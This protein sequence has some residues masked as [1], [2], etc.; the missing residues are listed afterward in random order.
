VQTNRNNTLLTEN[1]DGI[2]WTEDPAASNQF[3]YDETLLMFY[4]SFEKSIQKTSIKAGVR[5][6]KPGQGHS[7][8]TASP[9]TKNYFGLFPSLL[10]IM[11]S[12]RKRQLR[13]LQLLKA[14]KAPRVQ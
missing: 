13:T 14:G 5:E 4:G 11:L 2:H 3:K 10:S 7:V 12:M 9:S 6:S 1:Y 8:T